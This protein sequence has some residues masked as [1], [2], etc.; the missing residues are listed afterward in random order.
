MIANKKSGRSR[1]VSGKRSARRRDAALAY[2]NPPVMT[3]GKQLFGFPD[4]LVSK[5]RYHD[6]IKLSISL[7]SLAKNLFMW[8]STYDP[9]VTGGGHQPMYRDTFAAIYDQYAVISA[10]AVI[11]FLNTSTSSIIVCGALTDDDTSIAATVN[12]LCEQNHGVHTILP[13][14]AGSLSSKTFNLDWDCRKILNIDPYSSETYKTAVGSNP[15]EQSILGIWAT[16][17]DATS[18]DVT[19]DIM[20]EQTVLWSELTTPSS[21]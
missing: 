16:N 17:F 20:I 7:G 2:K 21:S 1:R 14:L 9:D 19:F 11:K 3:L 15:T 5:V 8:N 12:V 4:R 13:P 18:V 10:K 6:N